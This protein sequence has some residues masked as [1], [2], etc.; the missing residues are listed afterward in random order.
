MT[1]RPEMD[2]QMLDQ[3]IAWQMALEQDDAD[4]DA[5][6]AWLE[7]DPRHREAF[8]SVALMDAAISD[9]REQIKPL[10]APDLTVPADPLPNR[11][12]PRL[13]W[14]GAIAASLAILAAVPILRSSA[15]PVMYE[16]GGTTNRS[17]ALANGIS[18]ILPPSSRI[19]VTG[20]D[21]GAIELAR[22]EA[23]FD[24]RH[25]PGRTLTVSAGTYRISDI[26]TRFAVNLANGSFRV[27]V[28]EGVVSVEAPGVAK[29]VR[30][31]AGHQLVG[32]SGALT[33]AP[34]DVA[35]IG[36]WRR[37]RLSYTDTPLALVAADISRYSGKAI[38]V[39]PSVEKNHFSGSLVIGD[40]SKLVGDLAGVMG[41][42]AQ[43]SGNAVRI[44]AVR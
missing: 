22:G 43:S 31:G 8:D 36:S 2:E 26:G 28:A 30:L 42:A 37:G 19:V 11:W 21:A 29:P 41:I 7:A 35:Q 18:V 39:D 3:A 40:G 34:V 16:N 25:D 20:K 4:W 1:A 23:Y 44:S 27:G 10:L 38:I 5:Y 32:G 12:R 15:D 24:V 13:L 9:N 33:L 17:L 14:S 6:L